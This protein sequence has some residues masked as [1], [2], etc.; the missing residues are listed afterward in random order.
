MHPLSVCLSVRHTVIRDFQFHVVAQYYTIV[1]ADREHMSCRLTPLAT[2]TCI[3][4]VYC[5]YNQWCIQGCSRCLSTPLR[6]ACV[7]III[8]VYA[9]IPFTYTSPRLACRAVDRMSRQCSGVLH[10]C[11]KCIIICIHPYYKTIAHVFR[12]SYRNVL[13]DFQFNIH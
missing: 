12:R 13:R 3:H 7:T 5:I 1:R 10:M 9:Y 2:N 8:M 6:Q 4:L 11:V